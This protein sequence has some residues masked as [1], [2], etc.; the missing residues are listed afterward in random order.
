MQVSSYLEAFLTVYGWKIYN[1]FY[2]LLASTWILFIPVARLAYDTLME[3]FADREDVSYKHF[4]MQVIK[5][6]MMLLVIFLAVVPVDATKV[7]NTK[8]SSV[9]QHNNGKLVTETDAHPS[10]YNYRFDIDEVG[11]IPIL[12]SL[13]IRIAH[14]LNNVIYSSIPCVPNVRNLQGALATTYIQDSVLQDEI[15]RFDRE[16]V[17]PAR[18]R[19]QNASYKNADLIRFVAENVAAKERVDVSVITNSIA[20]PLLTIAMNGKRL[21]RNYI[22]RLADRS[23]YY[24]AKVSDKDLNDFA[25]ILTG[26]TGGVDAQ[27]IYSENPV[28]GIVGDNPDCTDLQ[29]KE[30]KC[31]VSCDKWLHDPQNGLRKKIIGAAKIK[32]ISGSLADEAVR[33]K[34]KDDIDRVGIAMIGNVAAA[35]ADSCAK[36]IYGDFGYHTPEQMDNYLVYYATASRTQSL[37][38]SAD[39]EKL[40]F[41]MIGGLVG[42]F[43]SFFNKNASDALSAISGNVAQ[44]Y[45]EIFITRIMLKILQ[46]LLLMGIYCFWGFY[47]LFGSYQKETLIKGLVLIFVICIFPRLM[48]NC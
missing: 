5:L 44:F 26:K 38:D 28:I 6:C 19:I 8:L 30:G 10:G 46:P 18:T 32:A 7:R 20:S 21:D 42:G 9:C 22:R 47:L 16:C 14:G 33:Q 4:K 40:E 12:P 35:K 11:K 23:D 29:K 37:L 31:I 2:A 25:D 24:G 13:V 34:C 43:L 1:V 3:I 36:K 15:E 27:I 48:G 45:G 39:N 17:V 41:G